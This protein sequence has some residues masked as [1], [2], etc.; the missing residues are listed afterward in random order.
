MSIESKTFASM[1]SFIQGTQRAAERA[2]AETGVSPAQFFILRS[3]RERP[4]TQVELADALGVTAGNVSQLITKLESAQLVT[5]TMQGRANLV[6]LS[7]AGDRL[8]ARMSPQHDAFLRSRFSALT[9]SER[10]TLANL[11]QK[12]TS[13]EVA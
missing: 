8:V 5:R 3:L 9:E 12:L 4:L 7:S 13:S 11:L 10:K 2:L 6:G 1:V